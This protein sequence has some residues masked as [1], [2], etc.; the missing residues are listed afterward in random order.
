M[1]GSVGFDDEVE[2]SRAPAATIR[3]TI[4]D[5][6]RTVAG[7]W[8]TRVTGTRPLQSDW[9]VVRNLRPAFAAKC[10][11]GGCFGSCSCTSTAPSVDDVELR[12]IDDDDMP[13]DRVALSA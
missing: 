4:M 7:D 8:A 5:A 2:T 13:C 1:A 10:H 12:F 9:L 3:K 11:T 6:R